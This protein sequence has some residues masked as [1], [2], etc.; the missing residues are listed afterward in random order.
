M[1]KIKLFEVA[2]HDT[3]FANVFVLS[4]YINAECHLTP[5]KYKLFL[6]LDRVNRLGFYSLETDSIAD[7]SFYE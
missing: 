5:T 6:R 4:S 2:N 3:D 7:L 1:R